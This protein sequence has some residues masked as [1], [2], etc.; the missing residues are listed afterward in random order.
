MAMIEVAGL[1]K[2]YGDT[3]VV[4]GVDF[5]VA[6]G[7]I[8]GI[9]GPNGAGKT[10]TVECIGGLRMRDGGRVRVAG[11]DPAAQ[12]RGL[13]ESL[14]VQLQESRLPDKQTVGEAMRL[15]AGFYS[16]PRDWRELLDRLGM[17]G[18]ER[19]SFARL[20]GGQKQRL[21]VALA[22][23]GNPKVAILDELTTGLDPTARREV[24]GLLEDLKDTGVT[25]LLVSH[26]MEEAERLCDRVAVIDS[27][28]VVA[29]DTP[30]D[31]AT[32]VQADQRM[33]FIP[34]S[35][36]DV[37]ALATL[38][39]VHRVERSGERVL[40]T[41]SDNVASAVIIA[42]HERGVACRKLR[43]DQPNLDDAFLALTH[44]E[45]DTDDTEGVR[46]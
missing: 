46:R 32:S 1:T 14:G 7:E 45:A 25:L 8:F 27:G 24:W 23:I 13:R 11:F 12:E 15:Y 3:Q 42:L 26:F 4:R 29:L 31:L 37:A 22:L 19:T 30:A 9:L 17:S 34:T 35:A 39:D 16:H 38:P 43:V 44:A 41:G 6:E 2:S 33:S 40:V 5:E 21:S 36:V 10:T 20:S 28:R 18:H